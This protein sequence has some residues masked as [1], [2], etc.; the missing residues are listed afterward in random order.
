[1]S[2]DPYDISEIAKLIRVYYEF[3]EERRNIFIESNDKEFE[4]GEIFYLYPKTLIN[5]FKT[6]VQYYRLKKEIRKNK[7]SKIDYVIE[8]YLNEYKPKHEDIIKVQ[9][10]LMKL[11][12]DKKEI[13]NKIIEKLSSGE[14]AFEII[15]SELCENTILNPNNVKIE[16]SR[17]KKNIFELKE[18][19]K[20]IISTGNKNDEFYHQFIINE[21]ENKNSGEII[22]K[23]EGE[24][25]N[26]EL[27][28]NIST[29]Y[30]NILHKSVRYDFN[31][32]IIRFFESLYF[33]NR[34]YND[35]ISENYQNKCK[36]VN[37]KR[38]VELFKYKETNN[39]YFIDY[40]YDEKIILSFNKKLSPY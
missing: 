27:I 30:K 29:K 28:K 15:N 32:D 25:I 23:I 40:N 20:I 17:I 4:E 7:S 21:E 1:M 11:G 2:K 34:K 39:T 14:N 36:I 33:S 10:N 9:N 5:D 35:P 8:K 26:D 3:D 31:Q 19:H 16:I 13:E 12:K 37:I 6:V 18:K 24:K 38:L 22:D